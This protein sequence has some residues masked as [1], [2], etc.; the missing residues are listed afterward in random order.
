MF[1]PEYMFLNV[2]EESTKEPR[3]ILVKDVFKCYYMLFCSHLFM[4]S[5]D[6]RHCTFSFA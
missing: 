1:L 4:Y 3:E 5:F 2:L 6:L